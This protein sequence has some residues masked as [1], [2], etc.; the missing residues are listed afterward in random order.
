ME[1]KG[2]SVEGVVGSLEESGGRVF[3]GVE[4]TPLMEAKKM[5]VVASDVVD[6]GLGQ[7]LTLPTIEKM[8]EDDR[9]VENTISGITKN[10]ERLSEETDKQVRKII[11][12]SGKDPSKKQ[13]AITEM[14]WKLIWDAYGRKK[15]DGLNGN[16]L[17][18]VA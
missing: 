14:K 3:D 1:N 6:G 16:Q 5:E 15:G 18:E 4:A 13:Q 9:V 10:Q 17:G 8:G 12:M 7:S 2:N 11:R